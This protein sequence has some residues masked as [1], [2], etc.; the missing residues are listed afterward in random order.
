MKPTAEGATMTATTPKA[1][2]PRTEPQ[3]VKGIR[4]LVTG[5]ALLMIAG[6]RSVSNLFFYQKN[7]SLTHEISLPLQACPRRIPPL[8][9]TVS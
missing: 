1:E 7:K 6:A 4:K 2:H 3:R 9:T 5:G 8:W